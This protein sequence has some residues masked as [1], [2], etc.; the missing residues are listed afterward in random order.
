[1]DI[2]EWGDFTARPPGLDDEPLAISI[3]VF[4]GVHRGHQALLERIRSGPFLPAVLTFRQSPA[5]IFRPRQYLGDIFS[6]DQKLKTLEFLGVRRAVLI[7]F[8]KKFSK[9]GGRD[10]IDLVRKSCRIGYM[11]L[12]VN[13]RCGRHLDTGARSIKKWMMEEGVPVDLVEPVL[14]GRRPVSSSRIRAAISAGDLAA[15]AVLLGRKVRLDLSGLPVLSAGE[16]RYYDAAS[17][18]RITP[19]PGVYRVLITGA[20]SGGERETEIS[21]QDGKIFIPGKQS[22]SAVEAAGV[23]FIE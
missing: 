2:L 14:E 20:A 5:R 21:I 6:L 19:P 4:D 15:A 16:G 12:G 10:F 1:M 8:S 23:E 9:I 7:D 17:V 22:E 18:S 3:G 13:F 11:A